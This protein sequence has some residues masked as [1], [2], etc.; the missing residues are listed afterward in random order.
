MES[1]SLQEPSDAAR[2]TV[3]VPGVVYVYTGFCCEVVAEPSP[4]SQVYEFPPPP[5]VLFTKLIVSEPHPVVGSAVVKLTCGALFTVTLCV[6]V[7][8]HVPSDEINVTVKVFA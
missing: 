7:S 6:I 4:K 5:V 2:V 1:M 8:V 3:Y